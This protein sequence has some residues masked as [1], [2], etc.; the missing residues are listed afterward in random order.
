MANL[1]RGP[2]SL[3]LIELSSSVSLSKDL[4]GFS[5]KTKVQGIFKIGFS[6]KDFDRQIQNLKNLNVTMKGDVVID[7]TSGKSMVLLLDPDGNRI[8]LFGH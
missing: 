8:Q 5:S 1:K 7:P 4:E 6:I 2:V 3:E